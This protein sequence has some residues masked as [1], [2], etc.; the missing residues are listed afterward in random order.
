[1]MRCG[2]LRE[3]IRGKETER[4]RHIG[5]STVN[6]GLAPEVGVL[7]SYCSPFDL[8][9]AALNIHHDEHRM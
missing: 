5:R 6:Q 3:H 9:Y 8:M 7:P 1:M 4:Y 2:N